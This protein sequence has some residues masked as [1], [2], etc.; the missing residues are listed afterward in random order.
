MNNIMKCWEFK[1]CGKEIT[2][3]CAAVVEN[4]GDVCWIMSGTTCSGELQGNFIKKVG[5]C[6]QCDYYQ[7]VQA[8]NIEMN[9]VR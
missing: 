9:A 8:T 5:T 1:K 7:Y 2:R 6:K 4:A 3:D